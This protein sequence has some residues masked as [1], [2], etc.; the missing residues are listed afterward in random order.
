MF[1]LAIDFH[2]RKMCLGVLEFQNNQEF[3][4]MEF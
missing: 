4:K 2:E 3:C 1:E